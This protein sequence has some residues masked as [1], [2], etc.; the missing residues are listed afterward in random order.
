MDNKNNNL[1]NLEDETL[2]NFTNRDSLMATVASGADTMELKRGEKRRLLGQFRERVIKVLTREQ[3]VE[4]WHYTDI[5]EAIK[6]SVSDKI[7]VKSD[8]RRLA[9][10]YITYAINHNKQVIISD[11]PEYVGD[12][13][14]V[15]AANEAVNIEQI[16]VKG[17]ADAMR[18]QGLPEEFIKVGFG[19]LCNF[20]YKQFHETM[21]LERSPFKRLSFSDRLSG[22][23][24]SVCTQNKL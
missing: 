23:K 11:N 24:C 12:I 7:I 8:Y 18:E 5:Y 6:S 22:K 13:A 1:N 16:E 15:V 19:K 3:V 20:H 17:S 2:I 21:G 14:L 9:Q 10:K 4:K